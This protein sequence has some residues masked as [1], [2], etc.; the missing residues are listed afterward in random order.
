MFGLGTHSIDQAL[1]L[2]GV[3]AS[4]TGFYRSRQVPDSKIDDAFI[5]VLQYSGNGKD[6]LLV[7]VRTTIVSSSKHALKYMIRGYNGSFT[8]F[9]EDVQES[10]VGRG[11]KST[12]DGF[13]VEDRA[14]FGTLESKKQFAENQEFDQGTGRYIGRYQSRPGSYRDY[15]SD[16]VAAIRG[17]AELKVKAEESMNGIRVIELARESAG[18]GVTMKW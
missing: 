15:Y 5:I 12:D 7:T 18:K 4:V 14:I 17:N 6:N 3:P 9:G 11:M 8:K 16:L 13:G 10:Q 1:L 2:F